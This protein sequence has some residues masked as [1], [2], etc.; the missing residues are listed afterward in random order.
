MK[1][2]LHVHLHASNIIADSCTNTDFHMS[3]QKSCTLQ[4]LV[5]FLKQQVAM[6]SITNLPSRQLT[7]YKEQYS[8]HKIWICQHNTYSSYQQLV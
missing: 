4:Q 7:V 5:I 2:I 3:Q 6:Y 8:M 1:P